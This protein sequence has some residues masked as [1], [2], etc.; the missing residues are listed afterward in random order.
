[1]EVS[2]Y[3]A[4]ITAG[5]LLITE[6]RKIAQLLLDGVDKV[7]WKDAIENQNILQKRSIATAHRIASL[8]KSRLQLMESPL[9]N[10]I[11]EGDSVVSTH[12]VIAAAIKHCR[13]LGDYLDLAVR[14]QIKRMEERLTTRVWEQFISDCMQ[15]DPFMKEFTESTAIKMRSNIHK[16]LMEGGYINNVREKII[17]HVNI[18]PEVIEYLE[19]HNE[20][21]VLRCMQ[22]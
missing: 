6:S 11:V 9:W 13:L 16:I 10:L 8:I 20:N 21:Y 7:G 4:N 15:R 17:Q 5:S 3:R 12:A 22:V 1:M 14:E 18:A 19:A 2:L